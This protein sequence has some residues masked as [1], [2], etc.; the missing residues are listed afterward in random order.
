MTKRLADAVQRTAERTVTQN[1]AAWM[2]ATVTATYDDGTC[3]IATSTGPVERVRRLRS[4]AAPQVGDRVKVA[5]SPSGNWVVED[6]T[7]RSSDSW[8]ALT[9]RAGFTPSG[10]V[11]DAPPMCR[12][13]S[14]GLVVLS[15]MIQPTGLT[16]AD[17]IVFADMP[18]GIRPQYRGCCMAV[19]DGVSIRIFINRDGTISARLITGA[20][21]AWFSLDGAQCR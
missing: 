5:R 20:A 16:T 12:K 1:S 11:G 13:T 9:L 3:D 14:D 8:Q 19:G 2:L 15:G 17:S 21:P 6:A 18:S 10:T 4:Y 7:A